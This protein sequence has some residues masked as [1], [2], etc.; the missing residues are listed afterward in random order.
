MMGSRNNKPGKEQTGMDVDEVFSRLRKM[1]AADPEVRRA[2]LAAVRVANKLPV[3]EQAA[4]RA[5]TRIMIVPT[6]LMW[7]M[8]PAT[9]PLSMMSDMYL[10]RESSHQTCPK[11]ANSTMNMKGI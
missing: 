5:A 3:I 1:A 7:F 9:M 2:L 11:R 8:S 4:A 10:G 6:L